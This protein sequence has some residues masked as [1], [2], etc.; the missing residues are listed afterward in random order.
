[1]PSEGLLHAAVARCRSARG[2][3]SKKTASGV[4]SCPFLSAPVHIHSKDSGAVEI[5]I[6]ARGVSGRG[7]PKTASGVATGCYS[8]PSAARS[9]AG[10]PSASRSAAVRN[11]ASMSSPM[12]AI[13][14]SRRFNVLA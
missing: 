8:V 10:A 6:M 11:V 5:V 9:S 7:T 12:R 1:M 14:S 4:L 2:V 13:W 3:C